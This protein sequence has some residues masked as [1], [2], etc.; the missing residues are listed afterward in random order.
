MD[1][2]T[3]I[4]ESTI[5]KRYYNVFGYA[6]IETL[7]ELKDFRRSDILKFRNCGKKTLYEIEKCLSEIGIFLKD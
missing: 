3:K 1:E 7:G 5:P 4:H 6:E 2:N